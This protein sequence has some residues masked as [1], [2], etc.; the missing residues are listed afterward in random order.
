MP[1]YVQLNTL[2]RAICKIYAIRFDIHILKQQEVV[3]YESPVEVFATEIKIVNWQKLSL[4]AWWFSSEGLDLWG[5]RGQRYG[6]PLMNEML[7]ETSCSNIETWCWKISKYRLMLK[8][9][10]IKGATFIHVAIHYF[11]MC[12]SYT[13]LR[14]TAG[15]QT[16]SDQVRCMS[17]DFSE[18]MKYCF[19]IICGHLLWLIVS[20]G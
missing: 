16:I 11:I 19:S 15:Q 17:D 7:C 2:L 12:L 1:G 5:V 6:I 4:I 8:N 3:T 20:T 13:E 18:I 14:V 9:A 10:H